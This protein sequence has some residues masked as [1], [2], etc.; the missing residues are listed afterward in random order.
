MNNEMIVEFKKRFKTEPTHFVKSSGRFEII[1][2]HTDH[3]GG[4]CV[5][6]SCDLCITGYLALSNS[7]KIRLYSKGYQDVEISLDDLVLKP[8]EVGTSVGLTKGV[9]SYFIDHGYKVGGFYLVSR[10]TVFRGAGVSSSAA[11]ESLG[12]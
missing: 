7:N 2:N 10:S 4:L 8:E 3:N 11:F 6:A 12:T 1:G 5:A 9:A